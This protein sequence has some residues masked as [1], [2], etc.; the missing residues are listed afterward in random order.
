MGAHSK[1]PVIRRRRAR[2][3]KIAKLRK[4]YLASTSDSEHGKILEKLKK[5]SPMMSRE[6]FL[7]ENKPA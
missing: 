5:L 6:Q 2:K 3:E 1:T 4:R 7:R